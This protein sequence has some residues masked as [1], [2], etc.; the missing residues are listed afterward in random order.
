MDLG[1]IC[2]EW[3][4]FLSVVGD[5]QDFTAES[6][7]EL[8]NHHGVVY[9]KRVD[10][11]IFYMLAADINEDRVF[12]LD[13]RMGSGLWREPFSMRCWVSNLS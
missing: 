11:T 9:P 8:F 12:G 3:V 2:F 4:V 5:D 13:G 10:L 6:V 7:G 1:D